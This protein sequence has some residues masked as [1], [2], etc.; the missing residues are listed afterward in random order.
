MRVFS[1][2]FAVS[3]FSL[4]FSA[5]QVPGSSS[6][7]A[8]PAG[9]AFYEDPAKIRN[10]LLSNPHEVAV[11]KENNPRLADAFLNGTF[12]NTHKGTYPYYGTC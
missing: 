3:A 11:L 8:R 6:S 9:P 10:M 2:Q 4:D 7:V 1:E 5:I 12:G